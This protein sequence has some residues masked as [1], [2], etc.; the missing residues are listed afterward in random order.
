MKRSAAV[1]MPALLLA[2][3]LGS[4]SS[5]SASPPPGKLYEPARKYSYDPPSGW[6]IRDIAPGQATAESSKVAY[7]EASGGYQPTIT[8]V[9]GAYDGGIEQQ[10]DVHHKWMDRMGS[11][12]TVH[13]RTPFTTD[14]GVPG[15]RVDT[16]VRQLLQAHRQIEYFFGPEGQYYVVT[17][18][19]P[20]LDGN[21][22]DAKFDAA[23]KTFRLHP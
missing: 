15:L 5:R 11:E 8:V 7:G 1:L 4:C 20:P 12:V 23:M 14:F 2:M 16:T 22:H 17:C 21:A 3:L 6:Q 19:I 13:S 18:S 10:V 9:N